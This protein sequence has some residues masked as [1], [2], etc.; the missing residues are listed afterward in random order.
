MKTLEKFLNDVRNEFGEKINFSNI[1][2]EGFA[3]V[4]CINDKSADINIT[5]DDYHEYENDLSDEENI[6]LKA[7]VSYT[8]LEMKNQLI[9]I[10][11]TDHD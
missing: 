2:V 11:N 4:V 6:M 8:Q 1:H 7:F 3:G 9:F 10:K 5:I